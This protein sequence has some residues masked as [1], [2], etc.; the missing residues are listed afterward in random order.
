LGGAYRVHDYVTLGFGVYPVASA[1]G[2]Y[3]YDSFGSEATTSTTLIFLEASP[4]IAFNLPGGF[5]LGVGYRI[6]YATLDRFQG[7]EASPNLDFELQGTNFAGVR[8]GLQW[9]YELSADQ[10]IQLGVSYRHRT[11]T[12]LEGDTAIVP[13]AATYTD[14]SMKFVLPSRLISGARFDISDLGVAVD[15]EY[16]FNSQ[17]KGYPLKGTDASGNDAEAANFFRWKNAITLRTGVEYRLVDGHVPVRAGYIWDQKTSNERFPTAFGTPPGD[18]HVGTVGTG[19]KTKDWQVNAAYAYRTVSGEVTQADIDAGIAEV[20]QECA[21]C[22][23]TGTYELT[24]HGVY[25]DFSY[26]F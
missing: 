23:K 15:V 3:K 17:N 9:A 26:D 24:M 12:T 19:W 25:I 18:T 13:V 7:T 22:S 16:G 21:F 5:N 4:G 14:A 20:G 8:A 2:E 1:G 6:T 10:K 11:D